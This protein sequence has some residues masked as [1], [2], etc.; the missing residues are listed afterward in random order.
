VIRL[1]EVE[2]GKTI[3]QVRGVTGREPLTRYERRVLDEVRH[4]AVDGVVPADALTTGPEDA[5]RGWHREFAMEVIG[6]AQGRGL[7]RDRWPGRVVSLIGVGP[8]AIGGL[9]YLAGAVGG[10]SAD[11][12]VLAGIAGGVAG[13]GIVLL[14]FAAARLTR[15]L[16]QLPTPEGEDLTARCLGLRENEQLDELPPAA[17]VLWGRP[18]AYAGA[19]GVARTAVELLPFGTEDDNGAWSRFGG[20]WHRVRVRYPRAW[21]PGWGKHPAFALFVAV[22]WGAVAVAALY[23]L[24]RLAESAAEPITATDPL[25]DRDQLDWIGRGVLLLTIRSRC[26]LG[27]RSFSPSARCPTSGPRAPR[28]VSS[29]GRAGVVRSSSRATATTRGTGTTSR[30]TTAAAGPDRGASGA[31]STTRTHRARP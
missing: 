26:S 12:P 30:S 1:E 2:P 7:T 5:S 4:K 14:F 10:D 15:S 22:L 31:T 21:P 9:L 23:G 28:P 19:M 13:A 20:R 3:C 8:F 25:F 6:E 18:F 29:C 17:V 16:A 24:T 11:S 27:G